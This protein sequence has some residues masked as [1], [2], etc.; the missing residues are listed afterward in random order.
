M[1]KS[2]IE[3]GIRTEQNINV[4]KDYRD[5]A[6]LLILIKA[7][8]NNNNNN[9]YNEHLLKL[10]KLELVFATYTHPKEKDNPPSAHGY[11][12]FFI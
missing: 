3:P 6:W 2:L 12:N 10:N 8:T 11:L 7:I 5:W 1:H 9:E 4:T